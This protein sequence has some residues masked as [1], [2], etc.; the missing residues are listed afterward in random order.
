MNIIAL[1]FSLLML[2]NSTAPLRSEPTAPPYD[3]GH[4][5]VYGVDY[6]ECDAET[7]ATIRQNLKIEF[8]ELEPEETKAICAFDISE[9]G[10]IAIA[11]TDKFI[12]VYDENKVFDYSL[13]FESSGVYG[14]L[15]AGENIALLK[16]R[17]GKAYVL[18]DRGELIHIFDMISEGDRYWG[19]VVE[20]DERMVDGVHYYVNEYISTTTGEDFPKF[21]EGYK[22]LISVD[23]HGNKTCL[24]E[25]TENLTA[26]ERFV[27]NLNFKLFAYGAVVLVLWLVACAIVRMVKKN[28]KSKITPLPL[29]LPEKE[30]K[31]L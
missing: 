18:S 19:E 4:G 7:E 23:S 2:A 17:S 5:L 11:T 31:A 13:K 27:Y 8:S 15:W 22:Y 10:R 25:A 20:V 3:L 28:I 21:R 14:V 6:T 16:V 9:S 26:Y 30:D 1:I 12:L 29:V 24:Y